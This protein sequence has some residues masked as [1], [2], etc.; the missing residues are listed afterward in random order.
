MATDGYST[1]HVVPSEGEK[2]AEAAFDIVSLAAS[3]TTDTERGGGEATIDITIMIMRP[4]M[5]ER[6]LLWIEAR[7]EWWGGKGERPARPIS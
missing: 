5:R 2:R 6:E 4:T 1:T 7:Q 3:M